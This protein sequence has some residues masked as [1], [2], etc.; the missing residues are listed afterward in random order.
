MICG[1]TTT[2]TGTNKSFFWPFRPDVYEMTEFLSPQTLRVRRKATSTRAQ[3]KS[4]IMHARRLKPCNPQIDAFI[5][6][7]FSPYEIDVDADEAA[8]VT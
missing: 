4:E 5:Y 8:D 6:A 2:R 3:G 7:D 1:G